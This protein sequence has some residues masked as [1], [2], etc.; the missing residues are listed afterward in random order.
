[1]FIA[2]TAPHHDM[3]CVCELHCVNMAWA[4][5]RW[6]VPKHLKSLSYQMKDVHAWLYPYFFWYETPT[7][8]IFLF[9][10]FIDREAG[11]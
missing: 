9:L 8:W 11:K 1:M 5:S 2:S 7:F 3:A 10:I 4:A 6:K